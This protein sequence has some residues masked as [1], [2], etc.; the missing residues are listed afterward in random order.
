MIVDDLE[1]LASFDGLTVDHITAWEH[2]D[3]NL[4]LAE[5]VRNSVLEPMYYWQLEHQ[6]LV[7]GSRHCIFTVSDGTTD[8]RETMEYFSL[9]QRREKL[10]AGWKQF[11]KDLVQHE[12]KAKQET[13]TANK[14]E[15]FPVITFDVKGTE[16]TTNITECLELVKSRS[17]IE[18]NRTLETD[19]DFA[20]KDAF[21]KATKKA[22]SDLKTLA[23]DV[24][25]KFV[26]YSEFAAHAKEID[27]VLQKM[28]SHGE[29]QVKTAKEEKKS[30]I[31]ANAIAQLKTFF[32]ELSSKIQNIQIHIDVDFD[33]VMKNKRTIESLQNS[34]DTELSRVKVEACMIS[35]TV[36][37]NLD[38]LAKLASEY[39]FLF[40]DYQSLVFADESAFEAIIKVR[41]SEHKEAETKRLE[42]ER[43]QIRIDEERKAKAK[44]EAEAAKKLKLEQE[45]EAKHL[46][47][48]KV[49]RP[50]STQS[51]VPVFEGKSFV[52]TTGD[53]AEIEQL[54]NLIGLDEV[55]TITF[56]DNGNQYQLKI[57]ISRVAIVGK[58]T[59]SINQQVA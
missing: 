8:N 40:N 31:K 26:S 47:Q 12:L 53:I 51:Q 4:T 30:K 56:D 1:L 34:V 32:S 42:H 52:T 14:T 33:V 54:A 46:P 41:I 43:E 25:N 35:D 49:I 9:P 18:I 29:K 50:T 27:A 59:P 45:D 13:V 11:E 48:Q 6:L 36:S 10:I 44:L 28:Q 15:T 37:N 7:S 19:Q 22:R 16:I 23:Q 58:Q 24:Q 17:E 39:Q 5:N 38:L 57:E 20:D 55:G 3:W 21:N 2:K